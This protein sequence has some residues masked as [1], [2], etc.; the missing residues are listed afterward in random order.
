MRIATVATPP[1][2]HNLQLARQIGVTDIVGRFPGL[3]LESL[4]ALRD[5]IARFDLRLSVIEGYIP[6]EKIVHG[7]DG[8]DQQIEHFNTLLRNMGRAGVPICCYNFM[9]DDDWSRTGVDTLERGGALVTR[10]DIDELQDE[11]RRPIS[12]DQLWDHLTYLLQRIVPVAEE[13]G[14]KLALHPDDPPMS[15][16]HGQARIMRDLDAFERVVRIV[17]SPANGVCFCQGSFAQMGHDIPDAIRRLAPHIHYVHFR[18]VRGRVPKF[19]ETF[20][21]NGDTDMVAAMRTYHEIGFTGPMRPDHVPT[22]IGDP[23]NQNMVLPIKPDATEVS[24]ETYNAP[25]GPATAG[26]TM[27]GRLFAVGYMRGLIESA[28]HD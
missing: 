17:P 8:R 28:M 20:H 6:H 12:D 1:S 27:T 23:I 19:Q 7:L 9:P 4:I 15:P 10:F 14:V 22:L 26:Y 5:R 13:A 21:D 25:E 18:D 24:L 11:T 2:D 3:Q 16:L